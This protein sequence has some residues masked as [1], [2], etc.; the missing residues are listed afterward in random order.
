M[1]MA[2]VAAATSVFLS[3][4]LSLFCSLL[5]VLLLLLL[6]ETN[7]ANQPNFLEQLLE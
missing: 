3:R 2:A 7:Q 1:S 6:L 4:S 5:L